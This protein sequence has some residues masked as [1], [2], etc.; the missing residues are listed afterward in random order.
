MTAKILDGKKLASLSEEEI[1]NEVNEIL[2]EKMAKFQDKETFK[3]KFEN[4]QE[5]IL[6][7]HK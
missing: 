4:M 5:Q 1:K 3:I 7:F 2:R 6:N